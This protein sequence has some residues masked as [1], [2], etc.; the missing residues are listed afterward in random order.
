MTLKDLSMLRS[1]MTGIRMNVSTNKMLPLQLQPIQIIELPEVIP[2]AM[3]QCK[4][5]SVDSDSRRDKL[6]F[7]KMLLSS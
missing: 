4:R 7:A 3:E 1:E 6:R 5:Q 2:S